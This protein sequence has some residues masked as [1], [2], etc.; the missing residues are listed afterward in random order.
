MSNQQYEA[1]Y[2]GKRHYDKNGKPLGGI[3]V[4][5]DDSYMVEVEGG[6]YKICNDAYNSDEVLS[7]NGKTNKEIL[8]YIHGN[9]SCKFEQ[10]KAKSGDFILCRLVVNDEKKKKYSGTVRQVLDAMQSEHSCRVS[11]GD[12]SMKKGGE[13]KSASARADGCAI[14]GKTRA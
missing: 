8:D 3:K 5:V 6:E 14:R 13:I 11:F 1:L 10:S 2:K 9:F 4:M 12:K 7:F